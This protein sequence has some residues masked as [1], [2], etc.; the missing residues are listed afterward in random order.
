MPKGHSLYFDT[1][2]SKFQP[3]PHFRALTVASTIFCANSKS[4]F[5]SCPSIIRWLVELVFQ[6]ATA[7]ARSQERRM[8]FMTQPK[9]FSLYEKHSHC[10]YYFVIVLWFF[11][12]RMFFP[13][14]VCSFLSRSILCHIAFY[15]YKG[16]DGCA[17]RQKP[18][19]VS[20]LLASQR[21]SAA[22]TELYLY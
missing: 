17:L 19:N 2:L 13:H 6:C 3:P 1:T 14:S 9:P 5:I 15:E 16:N 12:W 11:L 4:K 7:R 20:E 8:S 10:N 22:E 21:F 18:R